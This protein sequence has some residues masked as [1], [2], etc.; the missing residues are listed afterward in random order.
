MKKRN[1]VLVT[2]IF[3]VAF[4]AGTF[5]YA[6]RQVFQAQ[7]MG[8]GTQMGQNFSITLTI[9]EYSP[10]EDQKV[11]LDAFEKAGNKGLINALDKMK[12]KGHISVTGTMGYDVSYAREFQSASGRKIRAITKR[13][14]TLGEAWTDSRSMDYQLTVLELDLNEDKT[15]DAGVLMPLVEFTVDKKTNELNLKLARNPWKL[16]NIQDRSKK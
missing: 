8:Q 11:L 9:D 5:G 13:P 12:S 7:S 15:K 2:S 1:S 14:V 6:Q 16:V 4:L 3:A 10:P